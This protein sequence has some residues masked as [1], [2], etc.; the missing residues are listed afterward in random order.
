MKLTYILIK[1][2]L[3]YPFVSAYGQAIPKFEQDYSMYYQL[4]NEADSLEYLE[5]YIPALETFDKAFNSVSYVHSNKYED[6][7]NLAIKAN[8]YHIAYEYGKMILINS[9]NEK[10]IKSKSR[11][12]KRSNYFTLLTD[13]TELYLEKHQNRVN[14][15]YIKLIDSLFF[16]DQNIIRKNKSI[17]GNFQID[18]TKFP[19]DLFDLDDRN[20]NLLYNAIQEYGFPSEEKVGRE[21][22]E[23]VFIIMLHNI[24][25][26]ENEKYHEEFLNY[27]KSGKYSPYYFSFWYEQYQTEVNG[28]TFFSLWDGNTS[29]E[30]LIRID[31]NRRKFFLKGVNSW[32]IEKGR[33][34]YRPKSKW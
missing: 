13:S 23:D 6:A 27:M 24:R 28:Q 20:W 22:H 30:N 9:G 8:D 32:K 17:K 4:C 21:A 11:K 14:K 18:K 15:K 29:E 25:Q 10:Y 12:F 31:A 33:R 1:L 26:K 2:I 19:K 16:I 5:Q 3:L 7:Y 34:R